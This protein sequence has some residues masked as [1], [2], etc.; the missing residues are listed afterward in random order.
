MRRFI[1]VVFM[2]L[3]T[4]SLAA[5]NSKY[6]FT[7]K[8]DAQGKH[9][10]ADL[11]QMIYIGESMKWILSANWETWSE[12]SA[13]KLMHS[14]TQFRQPEQTDINKITFQRIYSYGFIDCRLNQ[15]FILN[16]YYTTQ[17][18]LIMLDNKFEAGEY[19]VNL[20]SNVILQTFLIYACRS[21][22]V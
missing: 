16:E 5:D 19:I 15:L 10:V 12:N 1:T 8:T 13:I 11:Q 4:V 20:E 3:S 17:Q 14:V 18:G 22:S 9:I 6:N 21:E 7:F 2:L